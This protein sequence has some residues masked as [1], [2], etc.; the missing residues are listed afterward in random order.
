M[1]PNVYYLLQVSGVN[2]RGSVFIGCVSFC[3]QQTSQS[4][5]GTTSSKTVK[6]CMH[7]PMDSSRYDPLKFL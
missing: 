2:G 3:V 5:Q 6:F 7:V 1:L 4:N